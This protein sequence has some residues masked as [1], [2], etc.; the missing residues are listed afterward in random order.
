MLP[1]PSTAEPSLTTAT[2]LRLMVSRR[3]SAG[4]SAIAMQTRATPG[5]YARDSSS[6]LR[7]ATLE[8]TS[9]LPP[10]CSR[11]VRSETLRTSTPSSS[12]SVLTTWSAWL[13]S[14]VSQVRSTSTR[15]GSESTTS[16]AVTIAPA[17]PTQVVSRPIDDASAVTAIRIV[18]ENPALGRRVVTTVFPPSLAGVSPHS[19]ASGIPTSNP[20]VVTESDTL[21]QRPAP[22][23]GCAR[24][25]GMPPSGG[26]G[27]LLRTE[28]IEPDVTTGEL[29]LEE[30][31]SLRLVAGL[32]TEL[33][34]I[35]EGEY[36]Q[37]R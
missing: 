31:H 4:F 13:E 37:L 24:V 25:H 18:I 10:R 21:R 11:N 8:L 12:S 20:V 30:R 33:T 9:I 27:H 6:R 35:T 5:V 7:S 2:V 15:V 36:R 19:C 23:C 34:D 22:L 17:S 32:S 1:R 16:S 3:A 29:E 26:G 14:A 28:I